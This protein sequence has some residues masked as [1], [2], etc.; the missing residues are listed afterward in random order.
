ME[1][2]WLHDD[3]EDDQ[4]KSQLIQA[5]AELYAVMLS[6]DAEKTKLIGK[7]RAQATHFHDL[8]ERKS[9]SAEQIAKSWE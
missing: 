9:A 2:W 8:A 3:L 6:T 1:R 7:Y 4:D 5:F